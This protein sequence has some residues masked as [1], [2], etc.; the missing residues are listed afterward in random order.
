MGAGHGRAQSVD[1]GVAE[2]WKPTIGNLI[3]FESDNEFLTHQFW[4]SLQ[5]SGTTLYQSQIILLISW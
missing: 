1:L 5:Y 2:N 4:F 3:H